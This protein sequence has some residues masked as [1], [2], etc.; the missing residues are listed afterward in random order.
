VSILTFI[1]NQQK[2]RHN[3]TELGDILVDWKTTLRKNSRKYGP[4]PGMKVQIP[5]RM[6]GLAEV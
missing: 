1:V 6:G 5:S 3:K 2:I 4:T